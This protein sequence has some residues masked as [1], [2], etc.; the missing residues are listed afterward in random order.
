MDQHD[1]TRGERVSGLC[2]LG[3]LVTGGAGWFVAL[4]AL[5]NE[6]DASGAGLALLASAMAFG[7]LANALFRT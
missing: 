2:I 1:Q 6:L 7:L 4:I 3:S 5:V